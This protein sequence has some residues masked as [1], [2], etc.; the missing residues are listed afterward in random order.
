MHDLF[1]WYR[2]AGEESEYS[3]R[4]ENGQRV[5]MKIVRADIM[6]RLP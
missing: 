3:P 4:K 1:G 6:V 5:W 2:M